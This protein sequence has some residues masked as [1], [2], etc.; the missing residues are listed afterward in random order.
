LKV[1]A[2]VSILT[3]GHLLSCDGGHARTNRVVGPYIIKDLIGSGNYGEVWLGVHDQTGERVAIK[4]IRKDDIDR[5]SV[6]REILAMQ[7]VRECGG[8]PHLVAIRQH[9]ET[10]GHYNLVLEVAEAGE[11]FDFLAGGGYFQDEREVARM[12]Q[13]LALGLYFLHENGIVHQDVK[14]GRVDT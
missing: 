9:E 5:E 6:E 10:E 2:G 7:I 4:Q 1:G 13:E 14:P 8:H 3:L 12:V 11:L